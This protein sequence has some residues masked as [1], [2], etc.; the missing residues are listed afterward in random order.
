L[1]WKAKLTLKDALLSAW[2]LEQKIRS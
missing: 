1:G 2:N